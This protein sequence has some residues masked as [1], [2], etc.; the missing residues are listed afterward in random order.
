MKKISLHVPFPLSNDFKNLVGILW[1]N[2]MLVRCFITLS[3]PSCAAPL[4]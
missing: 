4:H 2:V 1:C 3:L